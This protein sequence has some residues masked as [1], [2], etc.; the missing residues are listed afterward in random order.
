MISH[1]EGAIDMARVAIRH[2]TDLWTRHP[3]RSFGAILDL[4]SGSAITS[5]VSVQP[6]RPQRIIDAD[7]S[8]FAAGWSVCIPARRDHRKLRLGS[9]KSQS[10]RTR[11]SSQE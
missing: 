6:L 9:V 1:H 8:S 3:G 4:R 10:P 7:S 11:V 2:A 5:R